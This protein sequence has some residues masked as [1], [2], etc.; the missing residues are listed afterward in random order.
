MGIF[1]KI[2]N[3]LNSKMVVIAEKYS[4]AEE[5]A[6]VLKCEKRDGFFEGQKYFIVW[7]DGHLCT[8]YDPEDYNKKFKK[9]ELE[10]L[11]IIPN[12][13]WI[14]T[15]HGKKNK[16]DLIK[17]LVYRED[18]DRVCIATDSAREGNL[19]GDYILM[20][21]ENKKPVYRVMI[22]ALNR[23]DILEG[24]KNIKLANDFE[25]LS[26]AAQARDEID[27]L[28]GCN[29]SRLYSLVNRKK[30]Y[31][32]RCKT[33]ILS[34]ICKKEEEIN[35]HEQKVYYSIHGMF[36]SLNCN[37]SGVLS[38]TIYNKNEADKI[39]NSIEGHP[40]IVKKVTKDLKIL[41]PDNLFNL[42]DL[43][44]E[45]NRRFGY[46]SD[47]TY[48][49]SQDL[50][51]KHK[52]ISYARTDCRKVKN[53]NIDDI[54]MTLNCI[55][56]GNFR[57]KICDIKGL[58]IFISRCVDD[59]KVVE[60]TA[61]IPLPNDN[62]TAIYNSLNESERNIYNLI[63]NNFIDNFIEDYKYESILVET[64]V[65]G[66]KFITKGRRVI[67]NG[68]NYNATNDYIEISEGDNVI[69]RK[70]II[71]KKISKAPQRYTDNTLFELLENPGRFV[72]DKKLK[73][74]LKDNGIGTNATRALI[75]RD[76]IKNEYIIREGKYI[77]PSVD[78]QELIRCLKTE[79]LT[80]PFFTAEIEEQLQLI[81]DGK[82]G[83]DE[84]IKKT[85]SFIYEHVQGVKKEF[86][87]KE[88]K[89]IV[90]KCPL[91]KTGNIVK[92]ADKGFGCT[93]LKLIGCRFYISNLI[94]GANI[95]R[96]QVIKLVNNGETDSLIFN[97]SKGTF[98]AKIIWDGNVTKFK[99]C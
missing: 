67:E 13:F 15:R 47:Y 58:E 74:I 37:Y 44:R 98:R 1:N 46:A 60:H 39:L 45:A 87:I 75:L 25:G 81:E 55:K 54:K 16:L 83:K 78:G 6:S 93:N 91:C 8:L 27:W 36:T 88:E 59:S 10:D 86:D 17:K 18:V 11:P 69:C 76:L 84:L 61:I 23:K 79:K 70:V 38:S 82:L 52:I 68:W 21:I 89:K 95:D 96:D 56:F 28:I 49:V 50:Y 51:E 65:K 31:I 64:E 9:W 22:N 35:A 40:G 62:I 42:N 97:G 71:D 99:K 29:L 94:L 4:A 26:L 3:K 34:I 48:Y 19:I 57:D 41:E 24:F 20:A 90:C 14:K 66:Y 32:G 7:S 53:S 30:Y 5:Y 63:V 72:E 33:V 80:E 43:I 85:I 92:A 73:N 12:G 2:K 77:L